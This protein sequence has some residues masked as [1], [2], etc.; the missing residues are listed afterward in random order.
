MS[1][2]L[3]IQLNEATF[4]AIAREAEQA[5]DSPANI[6]ASAL[7]SQ[8]NKNGSH[9]SAQDDSPTRLATGRLEDLFGCVSLHWPTGI[10]NVQIDADLARE[11]GDSHEPS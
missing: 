8:F 1:Q 5:G 7:E 11:Y 6:A 3:T 9:D 10:D 2:T 4:A